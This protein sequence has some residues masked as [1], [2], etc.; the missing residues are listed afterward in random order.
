MG[1]GCG[2]LIKPSQKGGEHLENCIVKTHNLC[3][4]KTE[5][6]L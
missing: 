1:V 5:Q 4:G 3:D 2:I 6:E